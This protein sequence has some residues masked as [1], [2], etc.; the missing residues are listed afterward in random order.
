M[1]TIYKFLKSLLL[2]DL[3]K[4]MWLTMKYTPQPWTA[5]I[6]KNS[7]YYGTN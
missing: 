7:D 3:M 2:I 4:G 5:F 1:R 6:T